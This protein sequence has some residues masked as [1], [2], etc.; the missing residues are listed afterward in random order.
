MEMPVAADDKRAVR[1]D[2]GYNEVF[3]ITKFVEEERA[4]LW[5]TKQDIR[6]NRQEH[7]E[8]VMMAQVRVEVQKWLEASGELYLLDNIMA[9]EAGK[10]LAFLEHSQN[11]KKQQDAA[12]ASAVKRK[13]EEEATPKEPFQTKKAKRENENP[14]VTEDDILSAFAMD[15]GE[16]VQDEDDEDDKD[17]EAA[18]LVSDNDSSSSDDSPSPNVDDNSVSSSS[19]DSSSSASIPDDNNDDPPDDSSS[20]P[21]EDPDFDLG[22]ATSPSPE[23]T[24]VDEFDPEAPSSALETDPESPTRPPNRSSDYGSGGDTTDFL[25]EY[26]SIDFDEASPLLSKKE[27]GLSVPA[28]PTNK[29]MQ[30]T[31]IVDNYLASH[32]IQPDDSLQ[33]G[34][35]IKRTS[36][37]VDMYVPSDDEFE[38]DDDGEE[39]ECPICQGL[40]Q[41]EQHRQV[42]LMGQL[43]CKPC[44]ETHYIEAAKADANHPP[45]KM[46]KRPTRL[47]PT[48]H[49]SIPTNKTD[50]AGR[51]PMQLHRWTRR[52]WISVV[53]AVGIVFLSWLARKSLLSATV[54]PASPEV[55]S[56]GG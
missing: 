43:L 44:Y 16:T 11:K 23:P 6:R 53:L 30:T 46:R 7:Q 42:V 49:R 2:E 31:L 52:W 20:S 12:E 9:L 15:V 40:V 22:W 48:A 5:W 32:N 55:K 19:S 21:V 18:N 26:G 54:P 25:S 3:E 47:S 39:E 37:L 41:P 50:I 10:I 34:S 56:S 33:A 13:E 38:L 29:T 35:N 27:E 51:L 24:P 17:E 1:I 8:E 14:D 28:S 36:G 4:E 45:I